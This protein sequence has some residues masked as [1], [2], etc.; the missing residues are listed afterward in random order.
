MSV[1]E[2][3]LERGLE[4]LREG[5]TETAR[6]RLDEVAAVP[7]ADRPIGGLAEEGQAR[8]YELMGRLA[9]AERDEEGAQ[10]AFGQMFHLEQQAGL[11]EEEDLLY[12]EDEEYEEELEEASDCGCGCGGGGACGGATIHLVH[13]SQP[14]HSVESFSKLDSTSHV[15]LES[16]QEQQQ[17]QTFAPDHYRETLTTTEARRSSVVLEPQDTVPEAIQEAIGWPVEDQR[18]WVECHVEEIHIVRTTLVYRDE[19]EN[20][21]EDAPRLLTSEEEE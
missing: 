15:Y 19:P 12:D 10:R 14:Q 17:T 21:P 1:L 11:L 13:N 16:L 3:R 2:A 8:F 6:A 20:A 18:D 5:D 7:G 4:A 9:Q